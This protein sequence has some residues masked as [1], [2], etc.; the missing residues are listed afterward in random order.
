MSF[1]GVLVKAIAVAEKIKLDVAKAASE[2]DGAAVKLQADA[3]ELEAIA[4]AVEPGAGNFVNIGLS[5]V[6]SVADILDSGNAAAEQNLKDAGLDEALIA[7]VKAQ[8]A[9]IK[10]LV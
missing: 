6:E 3:P 9:N 7:A 5:L 8:L 10:K 4:N 2:V 1:K